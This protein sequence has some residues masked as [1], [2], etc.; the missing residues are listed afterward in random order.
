M[1]E[2]NAPI[3]P[4]TVERYTLDNG[5]VVL[6][7]ENPASP[8]VATEGEIWAGSVYD[9]DDTSGLASLTASMLRRGTQK[10]TFQELNVILDNVG[11]S[12]GLAAGLDKAVFSGH[13]LVENFDLLVDLLAEILTEPSFPEGELE[14]LRGQ[15]MTRLG[16]LDSDTGYRADRALMASLYAPTHPYSRPTL[17]T[18]ETVRTLTTAHLARFYR[19]YYHPENLI[20]SIVG[21]IE[22]QR[23]IDKL[24]ATLGQ[25]RVD[26]KP[27]KRRLLPA[28]TPTE[29]I[30]KRVDI[31]AKAQVDLVWGVVGLPRTSPDYYAAVMAN[32]VLGRLGLMGR[33]GQNVRDEQGLAYYVTSSFY[34]SHGPHPWTISAGVHPSNIERTVSSIL[35][36]IERLRDTLISDEELQDGQTY[37]IGS[38][39]VH[40]ET[41]EDIAEFLI[42]IEEFGLGLD[43]LQRYPDIIASITKQSIQDVARKYL[44]LDR[45]V[46]AMAGTFV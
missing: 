26:G 3:S 19:S 14:K 41:N 9:E 30:E 5:I 33:L 2:R 25:W 11:A 36:E 4:E 20:L 39:P 35:H 16:I 44:T 29:I 17:G 32:L 40:L 15:I 43:Y 37:L 31:P 10:H 23:A 45:Y 18:K 27:P 13:A 8:S 28:E 42:D 34:A 21:A 38:L 1:V 12:L 46:L 22:P 7:Q 24:V 6:V